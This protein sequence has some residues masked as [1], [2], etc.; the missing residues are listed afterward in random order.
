MSTASEILRIA[1][2][3][4]GVTAEGRHVG[5]AAPG[6]L[7]EPDGK[8]VKGPHHV[9]PACRHFGKCGGCQLQ[10][11]DEETLRD[12]VTSRVANAAQGQGLTV[13]KMLPTHLSGPK[14]RRRATL[15]AVNLG[16]KPAIG[17]REGKSHKVV[18]LT[19]CHILTEPL[20]DVIEALRIVLAR[21]AGRYAID[22]EL[23]ETDQGVDCSIKNLP[24]DGLEQTESML[25]LARSQ[26]LARLTLDQGYGA[27]ALWEPEPVTVTLAGVPVGFPSGSFLQAT[28]DGQGALVNDAVDWLAGANVVADLFSGLGTFSFALASQSK[29][30]AAEAARDPHLSCQLAARA[31]GRPVHAIHR[32]LFRN[33]LRVEELN[34]FSAILLDPPRAG[35]REQADMIAQSAV[36]RVVYISCNPSS[37]AR[38]AKRMVEGGYRL[39]QLRAV[40]QFRWSTHVE[41]SSLFVRPG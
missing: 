5:G 6:D 10:H 11:V 9:D 39:E 22:I 37:W 12:F 32:D 20:F 7:L 41:L 15:H 1:A 35:A 26:E 40:G 18:S 17:F 30:L 31:S 13:G 23:T 25:A 34:R 33:P 2:R 38:D 14:S 16:G 19:E 3:G 36:E 27:E 28:V 8:L 29:V 24:V 21:R 4:D